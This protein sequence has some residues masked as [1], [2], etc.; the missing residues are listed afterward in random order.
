MPRSSW[1]STKCAACS[2]TATVSTIARLPLIARLAGLKDL[3]FDTDEDSTAGREA[4]SLHDERGRIVGWFSWAADRALIR[5]EIWL[6]GSDR[7]GRRRARR[8]RLSRRRPD[9]AAGALA[10]VEPQDHPQADPRGRADRIAQS[11]GD[12]GKP[13]SGAGAAQLRHRRAGARRSRRLSRGQRHPRPLGRRCAVEKH[14]RTSSRQPAGRRPVRPL[15]RRRIR[16]HHEQ[17]RYADCER[18]RRGI[19]GVAATAD[20]H[21]AELADQ[22]R[23]RH[24]PGAG[25]RQHRRRAQPPRRPGA[26]GRQ[27]RA[28]AAW[29][30]ASSPRSRWNIP[31][32][33][34]IRARA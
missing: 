28:A 29:C 15:R 20:L 1:R 27:A 34:F 8:L 7:R 32:E 2:A 21:G 9:P 24:C 4:Q 12:A 30:G 14:C 26:A 6:W 19:T 11:P 16:R 13:R 10:R 31:N 3:R 33:R 5:A 17:R 23:H 25:R 22:R 18:A